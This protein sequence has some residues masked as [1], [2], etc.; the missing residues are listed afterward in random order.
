MG[1]ASAQV[2]SAKA[3]GSASTA[4]QHAD[5]TAPPAQAAASTQAVANNHPVEV[6]ALTT[7][8][9]QVMAN[10][11]GTFTLTT[12]RQPVR[13]K[14]NG[15]WHPINT[16][17]QKN[18]DGTFSAVATTQSL[19]LSGGGTA[20][21]ATLAEGSKQL[22]FAWPTALPRPTITGNVALYKSILAGIDLQVTVSVESFTEV[23]VVHDAKAAANPAL[24]ALHLTVSSPTLSVGTGP[25][26]GLQATD[27]K[28]S[29]VFHGAPPIMWDSAYNPQL[30]GKP[31]PADSGGA[32]PHRITMHT[33]KHLAPKA[34]TST[35]GGSS[36]DVEL[37]PPAAALIGPKVTYPVYLDPSMSAS[38]QH[39]MWVADNGSSAYDSGSD[40][41]VG[42][43]GW[44]TPAGDSCGTPYWYARSY[45]SLDTTTLTGQKTEAVIS[46][47]DLHVSQIHN[48]V[49]S[50]TAVWLAASGA[51]SSSTTYP[52]PSGSLIESESSAAGSSCS[53]NAADVEFTSSNLVASVQALA[54][55]DTKSVT[56]ALSS[57]Y[58][59]QTDNTYWKRFGTAPYM[60]VTYNFPPSTPTGL[61]V[62]GAVSCNGTNYAPTGAQTFSASA[63][64]NNPKQDG[65][66]GALQPGLWFEAH[67][68]LNSA[69]YASNSTAVRINSGATGT[70]RTSSSTPFPA[71]TY[72][73]IA[74]ADDIPGSSL[75]QW[76][77]YTP[78]Y[79][80]NTLAQITQTPT[81]Y[82]LDYPQANWGKPH[83]T[84]GTFTLNANGAT[85]AAGFSYSFDNTSTP[86]VTGTGCA[87]TQSGIVTGSGS[88]TISPPST[89]SVGRHVLYVRSF[90][91]AHQLSASTASYVF[92]EAPDLTSGSEPVRD[93]AE[94]AT[95][96]QPSGQNIPTP[97]LVDLSRD[98]NGTDKITINNDQNPPTGYTVDSFAGVP[99]VELGSALTTQIAGTH[100]IYDC[101]SGTDN[102]TSEDVGCEEKTLVGLI[103]Y[104]FDANSTTA[105]TQPLYRCRI[106][107]EHWDT[108]FDN[109]ENSSA[110]L[111]GILGYVVQTS[112][113]PFSNNGSVLLPATAAGQTFSIQFTAPVNAYYAM[114]AEIEANVRGGNLTFTLDGDPTQPLSGTN[115]NPVGTEFYTDNWYVPLGGHHFDAGST[116]TID[117]T[118][119]SGGSINHGFAAIVDFLSM[120]PINTV[121]Y[122]TLNAAMNNHGISSDGSTA[123]FDLNYGNSLSAQAMGAAGMAPGQTVTFGTGATAATFTMPFAHTGT[124]G[125]VTDNVIASGQI[126]PLPHVKATKVS[127]L[128][129]S[130][131]GD[132]TSQAAVASTFTFKELDDDPFSGTGAAYYTDVTM[133]TVPD[134]SSG[135]AVS[136]SPSPAPQVNLATSL[137][138]YNKSD[139][140]KSS[141]PVNLYAVTFTL[142]GTY[143][144]D[145]VT[146]PNQGSDTASCTAPTLHILAMSVGAN[147]DTVAVHRPSNGNFYL[148]QSNGTATVV[149]AGIGAAAGQGVTG[150]WDGD[151]SK[152][153][154]TYDAS[155]K[156]FTWSN[157]NQT[158][159]QHVTF[160]NAVAGDIP[161]AG[162]WEGDGPASL[163]FWRPS[164]QTFYLYG[165]LDPNGATSPTLWKSIVFGLSGDMPIAGDWDGSGT[166]YVGVWRPSSHLFIFNDTDTA[167]A[168]SGTSA[169]GLSG[170]VPLA[171]D[172]DGNGT[173]T[174]AVFR[175]SADAFYTSNDL[176]TGSYSS[177]A[178]GLSG[179]QPLAVNKQQ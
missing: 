152:T 159:S 44:S 147:T 149:P 14:Q 165:D 69:V 4:S 119:A 128:V 162:D 102:F 83:G 179:D 79:L 5:T 65:T 120:L 48:A 28:G 121:K 19:R 124:S 125:A 118:I 85:T 78:W 84:Q 107:T 41:K 76:S 110:T 111:E 177:L 123:N 144:L 64:D 51:F 46:S 89:L 2:G 75:D 138:Y 26:G 94:A 91:N 63:T 135:A 25:D 93:E 27:A 140:T 87:T 7:E 12:N 52:G 103:G 66:A 43:C 39:F 1:E 60:T 136:N 38:K 146:L 59:T 58:G 106:S 13:V 98:T 151:G 73:V 112:G 117:V 34:A 100:P 17:L 54:H 96:T 21:L 161:I 143:T 132:S 109:C 30:G 129:T 176:K 173:T 90:D 142:N 157:D 113:R 171:G 24:Q 45:F 37:M 88:T 150:D 42:Y 71:G 156:T 172:W 49:C 67:E 130:T 77:S 35:A 57:P 40:L 126:I 92:Y 105:P 16:N 164:N 168:I 53:P 86:A 74:R 68:Y 155:T 166:T 175:P 82:S 131:C 145:S 80:F 170:D 11:D 62:V 22:S 50:S 127:M 9:T 47:V 97:D 116:H 174:P 3:T 81:I 141:T 95:V 158:A 99:Y 55:S 29:V 148:R 134:W 115:T 178:F 114:G 133:P 122:P 18:T 32:V 101:K 61:T 72:Q 169:L 160:P 15:A 36:M 33:T 10:P 154:G 163:G 23:L 139:G 56:Y 153:V 104:L 6:A 8:T 70:W 31:G 137:P 20:P 167:N 108:A